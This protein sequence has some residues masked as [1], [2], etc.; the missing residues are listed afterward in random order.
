MEDKLKVEKIASLEKSADTENFKSKMFALIGGFSGMN[1][2]EDIIGG[3]MTG[4][5]TKKIFAFIFG[6]ITVFSIR[7]MN[8]SN[9]R[10][11]NYETDIRHLKG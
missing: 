9:L 11:T 7:E 8:L 6:I 1:A 5:Q 3:V 10:K 2:I 4:D